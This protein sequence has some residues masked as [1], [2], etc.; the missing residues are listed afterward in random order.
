[1]HPM[2][3]EKVIESV[4]KRVNQGD[5]PT[6]PPQSRESLEDAVL[7]LKRDYDDAR[8][9]ALQIL[10]SAMQKFAPDLMKVLAERWQADARRKDIALEAF[11]QFLRSRPPQGADDASK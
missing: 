1:M 11:L 4:Q 7:E 5:C 6:E 3:L 2:L 10:A 9:H 8:L